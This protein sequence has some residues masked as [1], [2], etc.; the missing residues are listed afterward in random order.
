MLHSVLAGGEH[1]LRRD[2]KGVAHERY[3]VGVGRFVERQV[4][5][6]I[7][8]GTD[9]QE[10]DLAPGQLRDDAAGLGGRADRDPRA[11]EWLDP[12]CR[13][14]LAHP[15]HVAGGFE[16]R[17]G[18][19]DARPDACAGPYV[20]T[21]AQQLL[22]VAA[23]IADGR[24]PV[25]DEQRER[26]RASLRQVGVHFDEAG[27]DELPGAL[28]ETRARG[29][30]DLGCRADGGDALVPDQNCGVH[31]RGGARALYDGHIANG[32]RAA[33]LAGTRLRLAGHGLLTGPRRSNAARGLAGNAAAADAT[34]RSANSV[35][36]VEEGIIG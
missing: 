2:V 33:C 19:K 22:V 12:F 18:Q 31:N 28:D 29:N 5:R 16:E 36:R 32:E 1:D 20:P 30:R 27:D 35:S 25:G 7:L 8:N 24:H 15:F 10:V 21:P 14:V 9:L 23:H 34:N 11:L 17:A 13:R 26:R 4:G 3:A 6:A